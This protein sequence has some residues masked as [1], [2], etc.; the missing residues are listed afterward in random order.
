VTE[1]AVIVKRA[2]ITRYNGVFPNI[3]DFDDAMVGVEMDTHEG[4]VDQGDIIEIRNLNSRGA[5][6]ERKLLTRSGW[7]DPDF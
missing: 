5:P 7:V 1:F 3:S 4:F 2:G 6:P